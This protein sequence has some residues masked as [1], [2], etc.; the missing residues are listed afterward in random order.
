MSLIKTSYGRRS[1]LKT[2]AL[3]GGGMVIG[4]SWLAS[5]KPS[6]EEIANLPKEWFEINGFLKIGDNGMA[7]IMSPNPE[8]GQNVKTS[9]PMIVAEE[10]DIAWNNVIVEQAPLNTKIYTNQLA[11]GSQSIRQGWDGLRMAGA[12]ARH[13]LKQAA[14]QKWEVPLEEITTENGVIH[15]KKSDQSLGYGEVA[16]LAA[17]LEV[18]K[19]VALKELDEFS[20]IGTATRNVDGEKIVTGKPLFGID[21]Y[22]EGMLIAMIVH[23][24][25]FGMKL[26]S[27]DA[28]EVKKMPGIKD[29]FS[30]KTYEDGF[31]KSM[32]DADAFPE[33]VVVVGNSTWEVMNA[34][35]ALKTSWEP[36]ED[37]EDVFAN[38]SGDGTFSKSVPAGAENTESHM[39]KMEELS[40]KL[41]KE[42][43]K[44]GDPE[45]A[46]KKA[47]KIIERSY[48]AP[49][50]AHNTMEPMN[51][52][53]DVTADKAVLSGP[54]QTPEFM[55][56]SVAARI[57]LP[58]EKIDLQM[59]RQG[60][61]FGRRLYG[62]FV[63]EAAAISQKMKSPIKLVYTREDDMTFGN[64]RPAYHARY[65]AALD[66]NNN[67][68]GFHVRAGGIPE[69]PLFANRF[70][71]GAIDNYLA[72]SWEIASNISVGAFRAPRSNF[73]AGAEQS[74]L[75][76]VAEAMGKD[77][78]DFRLELL[79]RATTNPVGE[80]ND[81]D[82]KRYA[83]VLELVREK[84]NWSPESTNNTYRGVSAY[85]CHN[86]YVANVLEMV[87]EKETPVV[88]KVYCAVDCG[89]VVNPI[90][91]TNMVEGGT[92]D[93]I[94]HAMYSGLTFKD[95]K[96]I[97][98]NFDRYR[99]IRHKEAPK[100]IEVHFVQNKEH[101]TGLG[102]PPFPPIMGSLANALYKATGQRHYNQPYITQKK[103]VS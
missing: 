34:K 46:F 11:G 77:P 35:K 79:E 40:T 48:T 95:G 22:K 12:T 39:E 14:A 87:M 67:I 54:I 37:Y 1:F 44:D 27:F 30:I 62:H 26:K 57:G 98:T 42:V 96:P 61:G 74:F 38:F 70:P 18:P 86:S 71:A 58:L 50:L 7:T 84:S 56:K 94:G 28:S 49:F 13:M 20:I 3:A 25:A 17:T 8:I 19:E 41:A 5:C 60:G 103:V 4:F 53:A 6:P 89:I 91:A 23:P 88:K 10:L 43:R 51:F 75:D 21:Q 100:E 80:K 24:P 82:A 73:I 15:H 47:A 72:E 102:E 63:V 68:I 83:G 93:G 45:K 52:Y 31:N 64:Y 78:F 33:L 65:R 90:A 55:E 69:S 101:P 16:S 99:M 36:F 76:E 2:S 85:F 66:E 29:V 9:M 92:V 59:T 32:F 97:Q 81:Y